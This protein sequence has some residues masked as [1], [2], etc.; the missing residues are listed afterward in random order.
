MLRGD[1]DSKDEFVGPWTARH[2]RWNSRTPAATHRL[3]DRED[4]RSLACRSVQLAPGTIH[5][6]C[7]ANNRTT[8]LLEQPST[9][10]WTIPAATGGGRIG[11]AERKQRPFRSA[12][13][14]ENQPDVIPCW[15]RSSARPCPRSELAQGSCLGHVS[16]IR[17]CLSRASSPRYLL[18]GSDSG[19]PGC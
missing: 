18:P 6:V 2:D 1:P 7:G 19:A 13:R 10:V 16:A 14:C 3:Q 5:S 15:A 17:R 11:G 9:G 8:P 12:G 4:T